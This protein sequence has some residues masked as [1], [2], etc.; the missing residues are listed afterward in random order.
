[1]N[2]ATTYAD[3][4]AEAQRQALSSLERAQALSLRGAELA[5]GL[6]PEAKLPTAKEAVEGAFAFAGQVLKQ[7]QSY[8]TRMTE[9]VSESLGKAEPASQPTK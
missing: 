3:L 7:Q 2:Q 8:A 5:A 6:V 9:I 1:M 4:A